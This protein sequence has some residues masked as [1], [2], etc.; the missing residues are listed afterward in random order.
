MVI[1]IAYRTTLIILAKLYIFSCDCYL[2]SVLI[3]S[4]V[5]IRTINLINLTQRCIFPFQ[6]AQCDKSN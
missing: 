3:Q 4:E 1:K 2:S 6:A 5:I